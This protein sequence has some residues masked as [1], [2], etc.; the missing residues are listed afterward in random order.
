MLP[1]N[2][3]FLT[4]ARRKWMAKTFQ[5]FFLLMAAGTVGE[6]FLKLTLAWKSAMIGLGLG[7]FVMGFLFSKADSLGQEEP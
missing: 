3:A 5:G 2:K 6:T 7:A 4:S 1:S